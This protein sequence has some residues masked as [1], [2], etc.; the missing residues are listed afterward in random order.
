MLCS[1][2]KTVLK[3]RPQTAGPVDVGYGNYLLTG[4]RQA[5]QTEELSPGP[6]GR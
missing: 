3:M 5:R 1:L 6:D 2:K 4:E